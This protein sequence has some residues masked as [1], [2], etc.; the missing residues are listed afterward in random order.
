MCGLIEVAA[1]RLRGASK[2]RTPP[3]PTPPLPDPNI[4]G[5]SEPTKLWWPLSPIP[6]VSVVVIDQ[7]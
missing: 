4:G 1:E 2:A 5:Q 6:L 7:S 3:L